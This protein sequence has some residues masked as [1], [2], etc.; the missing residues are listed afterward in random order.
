MSSLK[1]IRE[2]RRR[3]TKYEVNVKTNTVIATLKADQS[4]KYTKLAQKL[5]QIADMQRQID[6]LKAETKAEAKELIAGLFDAED[7]VNTRVVETVSFIF[8]LSKDPKPTNVVAHA[9]V[10]AELE[11]KL[12]PS[13]LKAL[14]AIKEKYTTTI[15]KE[16]SL[17][18][19]AKESVVESW[20]KTLKDK[21][22]SFV[23]SIRS[24][25]TKYDAALAALK[26]RV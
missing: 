13:L 1:A 18:V 8:T 9:K 19:A 21:I 15:Q 2:A 11:T 23:E 20:T 5:E 26:S 6:E 10:L 3:D 17:R 24:W 22:A 25:A 12:T 16:P 7:A 14:A 4:R